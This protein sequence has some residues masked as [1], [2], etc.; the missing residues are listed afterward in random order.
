MDARTVTS[1]RGD[2][3]FRSTESNYSLRRRRFPAAQQVTLLSESLSLLRIGEIL[4]KPKL[5]RHRRQ[6]SKTVASELS[7]PLFSAKSEVQE[8]AGRPG[9]PLNCQRL[10]MDGA[11]APAFPQNH[12]QI[13]T[14]FSTTSDAIL[15]TLEIVG[16][17]RWDEKAVHPAGPKE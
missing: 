11:I 1:L 9:S 6:P 3:R 16:V 17:N 2:R 8:H 15:V 7:M 13:T 4:L 10:A 14:C 5:F 12:S